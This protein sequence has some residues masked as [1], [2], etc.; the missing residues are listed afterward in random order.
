MIGVHP[1]HSTIT[2]LVYVEGK[3]VHNAELARICLC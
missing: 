2:N 3:D 1:I